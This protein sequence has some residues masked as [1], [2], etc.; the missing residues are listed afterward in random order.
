M[1][2]Q[3]YQLD[4][5]GFYKRGEKVPT[6]GTPIEWWNGFT[7]WVS[8]R[9][10]VAATATFDYSESVTRRVYCT[11]TTSDSSG[12]LG[13]ALWNETP[14]NEAGVS[15][16]PFEGQ[17][18]NVTAGEQPLPGDSIP[19]WPTYLWFMPN[20]QIVVALVADNMRG[21]RSTGVP[22]ARNYF[23]AYLESHSQYVVR[24]P[25]GSS[26]VGTSY[27]ILGYRRDEADQPDPAFAAHFDT[28]PLYLPG[29]LSEIRDNWRDIRKLVVEADVNMPVPSQHGALDTLL[30]YFGASMN[31]NRAGEESAKY[32]LAVDWQPWSQQ[33]V[34]RI[35]EDWKSR[36]GGDNYA[37]GVRFKGSSK[38]HW[39]GRTD[40]K[41]TVDIPDALSEQTLWRSEAL[42]NAWAE[43]Q[44]RVVQLLGSD[45]DQRDIS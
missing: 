5:C 29:L 40:G 13:V 35:I 44:P 18:G 3:L 4:K 8:F 11:A 42:K 37:V 23:R 12:N 27:E 10:N 41:G 39:L 1:I 43:A 45:E 32:R 16:I 34:D 14:S 2:V 7:R 25:T 33:D 15:Y 9:P 31:R 17:V 21:F 36:E 28:S 24:R 22:Q 19:G 38:I 20:R 6:F 30:S 26:M